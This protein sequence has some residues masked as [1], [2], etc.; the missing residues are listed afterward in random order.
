ML[1]LVA[2]TLETQAIRLRRAWGGDEQS[3]RERE[4]EAPA[5]CLGSR[6]FREAMAAWMQKREG[7]SEGR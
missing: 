6:D 3:T 2:P 5:H 1:D 7:H 4:N